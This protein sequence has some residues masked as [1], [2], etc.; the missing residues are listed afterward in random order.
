MWRLIFLGLVVTLIVYLF[1]R[2][3]IQSSKAKQDSAED[4]HIEDIDMVKCA[5]C[6]VHLPRS[7][8]YL[9]ANDFYCSKAHIE[10]QT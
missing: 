4:K 5:K 3:V 2:Q 8:A 9:V 7:E 10:K 1:K 6:S